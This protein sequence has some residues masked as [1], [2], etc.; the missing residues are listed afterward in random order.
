M[1]SVSSKRLQVCGND[2]G[3]QPGCLF[4]ICSWMKKRLERNLVGLF[5]FYFDVC[6]FFILTDSPSF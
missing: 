4:L 1:K 2:K 5:S 6:V 3:V